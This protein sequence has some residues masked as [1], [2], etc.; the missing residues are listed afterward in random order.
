MSKVETGQL[1]IFRIILIKV[2]PYL[3]VYIDKH[4]GLH[5]FS[6]RIMCV[7]IFVRNT[8]NFFQDYGN[9]VLSSNYSYMDRICRIRFEMIFLMFAL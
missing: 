6:F 3:F 8:S 1:P 2:P 4:I 7:I 5:N 9:L